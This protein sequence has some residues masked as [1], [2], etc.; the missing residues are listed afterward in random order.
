MEIWMWKKMTGTSWTEHKTN[1]AVLNEVDEK[2][3]VMNTI[4]KRKIKLIG[5]LLRHNVFIT[6]IIEGKIA[7]KR[8]RGRPCKTFEEI[9][10][11][12]GCTSY[13]SF[14]MASDRYDWL[15]QQGLAFKR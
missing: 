14:K 6:I 2:R 7:G 12:M 9:F 10:R 1:E 4:M 11:R 3:T 8:T 13:Q 15:Q 5:Q